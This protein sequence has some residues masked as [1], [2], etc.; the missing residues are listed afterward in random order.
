[1]ISRTKLIRC[2][3]FLSMA[4]I[5]VS[6]LT[7]VE[8]Q[9]NTDEEK[10][11]V[12]SFDIS[13]MDVEVYFSFSHPSTKAEP[14]SILPIS[15]EGITLAYLVQFVN[16]WE[17]IA[18]DKRLSPVL[19][20]DNQGIFPLEN[21]G[22]RVLLSNDLAFIEDLKKGNISISEQDTVAQ[23][24]ISFWNRILGV[25]S[26]VTKAEGDPEEDE[27]YWELVS[28]IE[29]DGFEETSGHLITTNWFQLD[30]WNIYSPL[31]G[32]SSD[33]RD[34]AGCQ[35]VAGAQML[36]YLH[37]KI[38][39]PLTAPTS[40]YCSGYST[41]LSDTTHFSQFFYNFN[42]S[43]WPAMAINEQDWNHSDTLSALLIGY[44]GKSVGMQYSTFLSWAEPESLPP[45]LSSLGIQSSLTPYNATTIFNSIKQLEMPAIIA[46]HATKTTSY[47]GLLTTYSDGHAFIA[48]DYKDVY[49]IFLC[50]Y[51]WNSHTEVGV[52]QYGE[53][54]TVR[55]TIHEQYLRMNWGL[56]PQSLNNTYYSTNSN[57]FQVHLNDTTYTFQY[58]QKMIYGF[59]ADE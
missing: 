10:G 49:R 9:S 48:D 42:S 41:Q 5:L 51:R 56:K 39:L 35:A 47:F 22:L 18:A 16:G 30:P 26:I 11:S 25:P 2:T 55:D 29:I 37:N 23:K 50:T 45:F 8:K 13:Q 52:H 27:K 43:A 53:I 21:N 12:S 32:P 57:H 4:F 20:F 3:V 40:G 46:A 6:C 28:M 19:A 44:V 38:G 59:S 14:I 17:L 36:Y 24:N 15:S 33:L 34:P 58:Q 7:F 31:W 54:M 1:M